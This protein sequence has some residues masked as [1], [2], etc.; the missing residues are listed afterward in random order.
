[1]RNCLQ[2]WFGVLIIA[3]QGFWRRYCDVER[4]CNPFMAQKPCTQGRLSH[5]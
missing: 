4:V 2:N 3:K 1:M 5:T